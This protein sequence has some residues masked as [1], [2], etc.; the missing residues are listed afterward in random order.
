MIQKHIISAYITL[1][2]LGGIQMPVRCAYQLYQLRKKLESS[3]QFCAEQER[4]I[5]EKY[6]GS[7]KNGVISFADE[8]NATNA[9]NALRELNEMTVEIEFDPVTINMND[10]Q[11]G[12]VSIDD[13]A[14]LDG[15]VVF[16]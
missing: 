15:F 16:A 2:H 11:S 6:H 8:D 3:Y 12:S 10:I 9:Q 7:V 5:I 4:M 1:S 13:I 14:N